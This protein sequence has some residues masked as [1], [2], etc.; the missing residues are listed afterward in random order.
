LHIDSSFHHY[1]LNLKNY[2]FSCEEIHFKPNAQII[3]THI[4]SIPLPDTYKVREVQASNKMKRSLQELRTKGKEKGWTFQVGVTSVANYP[5]GVITGDIE[6]L[7]SEFTFGDNRSPL[8]TVRNLGDENSTFFDLTNLNLVTSVKSQLGCG[9]CSAFSTLA[10]VETAHLVKNSASIKF[11]LSEQQI[12][13]CSN[14]VTCAEGGQGIKIARYLRANNIPYEFQNPYTASDGILCRAYPDTKI[15][16]ANAEFIQGKHP[17]ILSI[18]R[19]LVKCGAV[20]SS[21]W[22][23]DIFDLYVT[24]VFNYDD[25]TRDPKTGGR[26]AVQIVGWDDNNQAWKIKNS[27]G[28][29]GMSGFAWI[30]YNVLDIGSNAFWIEANDTKVESEEC[31]KK[32][33]DIIQKNYESKT[34]VSEIKA[35]RIRK[36]QKDD[37]G[38]TGIRW[39][40]GSLKVGVEKGAQGYVLHQQTLLADPKYK[41][42]QDGLKKLNDEI[43]AMGCYN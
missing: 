26:H 37:E 34:R 31:V 38:A 29:W 11:D 24:G 7:P 27:W 32:R 9:S 19:A 20:V 39:E 3:R 10:A 12:L 5:I 14:L 2:D 40:D 42:I 21:M 4:D 23:S 6:P 13:D 1:I 22:A 25:G 33:I 28:N 16:V 30:S 18:K 35:M 41:K 17:E 36:G 8:P 43:K 15:R